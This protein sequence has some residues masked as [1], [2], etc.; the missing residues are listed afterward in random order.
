MSEQTDLLESLNIYTIGKPY[1]TIN[2]VEISEDTYESTGN[3]TNIVRDYRMIED[4]FSNASSKVFKVFNAS[5]ILDNFVVVEK[6][7]QAF[8]S[9]VILIANKHGYMLEQICYDHPSQGLIFRYQLNSQQ[10]LKEL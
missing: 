8:Q 5:R 3:Y 9:L 6:Y 7:W 4:E 1:I 2:E 10:V